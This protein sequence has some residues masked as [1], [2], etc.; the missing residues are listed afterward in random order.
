MNTPKMMWITLLVSGLLF[1]QRAFADDAIKGQVLG[2]GAPIANLVRGPRTQ[3]SRAVERD[4]EEISQS[5]G[6]QHYEILA[7]ESTWMVPGARLAPWFR[8]C[9][10][11]G[12][13][14]F[15]GCGIKPTTPTPA[16]TC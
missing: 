1:A 5:T 14:P 8:G 16:S 11:F 7:W 10:R 13:F 9:K 15:R 3:S 4:S 6:S 2:G 12:S